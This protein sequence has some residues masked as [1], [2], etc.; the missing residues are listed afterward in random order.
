MGPTLV[1]LLGRIK[2]E[3]LNEANLRDFLKGTNPTKEF[4]LSAKMSIVQREPGTP[5]PFTEFCDNISRGLKRP[6]QQQRSNY[7]QREQG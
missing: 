6:P 7:N 3:K 5:K 1:Q 4:I 2:S